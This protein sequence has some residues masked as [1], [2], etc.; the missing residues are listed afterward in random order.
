MGMVVLNS[1]P[2]LLP[3]PF[4]ICT[5]AGLILYAN[6]HFKNLF[7][8]PVN[9]GERLENI[10]Q[11]FSPE[12]TQGWV[13]TIEIQK[14]LLKTGK[15]YLE[16]IISADHQRPQQSWIFVKTNHDFPT[17]SNLADSLKKAQQDLK[18]KSLFIANICH[19]IRNSLSMIHGLCEINL[20]GKTGEK[21]LALQKVFH[22]SYELK[23]LVQDVLDFSS[24]EMGGIF[25]EKSPFDPVQVFE[26]TVIL[27]YPTTQRKNIE[28]VA[29]ACPQSPRSVIGDSMKF[30]RIIINLVSNAIKF[31]E[32][33]FVHCYLDFKAQK[34]DYLVSI[35]VHD[36]GIGISPEQCRKIFEPFTQA[37][38]ST[39][40]RFG[41]YGLG[42]SIVRDLTQAMGG[43]IQVESEPSQGSRF[44]A[45]IKL[46]IN[47]QQTLEGHID[48]A[49]NKI[50]L[51]GGHP[52]IKN[53]LISYFN[54]CK[55]EVTLVKNNWEAERFWH[56]SINEAQPFTHVVIDLPQ[57][58]TP[59]LSHIPLD[60]IVLIAD[61]DLHLR[62]VKHIPKPLT[63]SSLNNYFGKA[64]VKTLNTYSANSQVD[65]RHI[66]KILLAEDNEVNREVTTRR[67]KN[68]G[69]EV[70]AT[71]DGQA[72]LEL[73]RS[74][75]FDLA[76]IDL[77]MPLLDGI[78]LV[79]CIRQEE[80]KFQRQST[81]LVALTAINHLVKNKN[82]LKENGL[83]D[84]FLKPIRGTELIQK[85]D[86]LFNVSDYH[87]LCDE[88]HTA[89][90]R[91]DEEEIED[92]KCAA[93]IFLRHSQSLIGKLELVMQ[94][95]DPESI[96]KECHSLKGMLALMSCPTLA[97]LAAELEQ[98]PNGPLA[99]DY[100]KKLSDGLHRL[101][102][103]LRLSSVLAPHGQDQDQD[104]YKN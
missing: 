89:L 33:G 92:L 74:K 12:L 57:D 23:N 13:G 71:V 18:Q 84:Y 16:V 4:I 34:S 49:K 37:E 44:T 91:A 3:W 53:R 93:R 45:T 86:Q 70:T 31:T 47:P 8:N 75:N 102:E 96:V 35:I 28:L 15:N 19:E 90:N 61:R 26:D 81:K 85:I 58:T 67:L 41:G 32:R 40:R 43:T 51:M 1:L 72:A 29:L 97:H 98:N 87:N 17:Q 11:H 46:S 100:G 54:Y 60:K 27:N 79:K 9:E 65:S 36:S 38:D 30:R 78:S 59:S 94:S 68:A 64:Y 88:F 73:W 63:L 66:L 83:D 69:H 62:G 10:F 95:A 103:S 50:L 20:E 101:Q 99:Q 82:F 77:Q 25:L 14:G 39:A 52:D 42:L 76:L 6:H 56:Q 48:L 80:I 24:Y 21:D 104:P 7:L 5:K 22:H 2:H 55:A